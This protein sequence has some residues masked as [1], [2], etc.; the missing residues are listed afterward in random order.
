MNDQFKQA[1]IKWGLCSGSIVLLYLVLGDIGL[2][3]SVA[4]CF[5]VIK[6]WKS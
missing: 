2:L 1:L 4:F 5:I 3:F 6:F